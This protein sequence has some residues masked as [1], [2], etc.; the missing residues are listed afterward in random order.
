MIV[1]KVLAFVALS[2]FFAKGIK[3]DE[4][5]KAEKLQKKLDDYDSYAKEKFQKLE[6]E[7]A[8]LTRTIKELKGELC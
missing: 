1:L 5:K 7:K 8:I 4:A 2:Y 6:A 3:R